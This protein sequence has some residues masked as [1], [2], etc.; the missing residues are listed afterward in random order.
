MPRRISRAR[1]T[2]S[3]NDRD[4]KQNA[5]PQQ[6]SKSYENENHRK[7]L[8]LSSRDPSSVHS[9]SKMFLLT[10]FCHGRHTRK[11]PS[12]TPPS[13]DTSYLPDFKPIKRETLPP[14]Y[15][16]CRSLPTYQKQPQKKSPQALHGTVRPSHDFDSPEMREELTESVGSMLSEREGSQQPELYGGLD[17]YNF[18]YDVMVRSRSRNEIRRRLMLSFD[19][20]FNIISDEMRRKLDAEMQPYHGL[21]VAVPGH[22]DRKPLGTVEVQWT[23]C[24]RT[25]VYQTMF[26]VVRG[27]EL[28]LLL[29]RHSMRKQELYRVDPEIA[30]RLRASYGRQL[31]L[32]QLTPVTPCFKME[33]SNPESHYQTTKTTAEGYD[34]VAALMTLE[35]GS[36][37]F[38]RFSRLNLKNLLYLQAELGGIEI[39][40][41]EIIEEDKL[42][43][44]EEKRYYPYS[45]WHLKESLNHAEQECPAQWLKVLEARELLAKY[46]SALLQQ[47]ELLRFSAPERHELDVFQRWLDDEETMKMEHNLW[48]A[49]QWGKENEKDLITLHSRHEGKDAFTRWVYS[50][51]IPWF[52]KRWGGKDNHREDIETGAWYYN[53]RRIKSATYLVSLVISGLLPASSMAVLY[54]LKDTAARLVTIFVYNMGFVLVMG[55]MVKARRIEIFATAAA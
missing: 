33:H 1:L 55:L 34:K 18:V 43:G 44:S 49:D 32:H 14:A 40:L 23:F 27:V 26:Y 42:S 15:T 3:L 4:G 35:P 47:A 38:R 24:G 41:Q 25:K 54:F 8:Y 16:S 22:A 51:F 53:N 29:G 50:R 7:T 31:A 17:Q 20:E 46:N 48:P 21:P 2:Q 52:H 6:R 30:T 9:K 45:V 36:S 13:Q 5:T 28:D 19:A 12:P 37:I 11:S 39:D 10:A